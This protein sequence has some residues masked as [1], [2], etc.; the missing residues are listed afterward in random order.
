MGSVG[1]LRLGL[2][3]NY[4]LDISL[5]SSESSGIAR[6]SLERLRGSVSLID[7]VLDLLV[8]SLE[9]ETRIESQFDKQ[10]KKSN[11]NY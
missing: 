4:S 3:G 10:Q 6:Q 5:D 9:R 8:G 2:G 11:S 1:R 7:V